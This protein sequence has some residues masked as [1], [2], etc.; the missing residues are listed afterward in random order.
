MPL[1]ELIF[2]MSKR[3]YWLFSTQLG[4]VSLSQNSALSGAA[5][6]YWF[7]FGHDGVPKNDSFFITAS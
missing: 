3:A 7:D 5:K 4:L 6:A 1:L 2:D